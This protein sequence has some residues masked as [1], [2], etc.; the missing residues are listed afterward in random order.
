VSVAG[1]A[2]IQSTVALDDPLAQLR[3]VLVAPRQTVV[4]GLKTVEGFV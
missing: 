2:S 4:S 3:K 1:V